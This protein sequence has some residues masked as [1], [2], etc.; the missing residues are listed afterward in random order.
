MKLIGWLVGQSVYQ[1]CISKLLW[2]V[3]SWLVAVVQVR[4]RSCLSSRMWGWWGILNAIYHS[5]ANP[6]RQCTYW[7]KAVFLFYINVWH[8]LPS[9]GSINVL[10]PKSCTAKFPV[11]VVSWY[12]AHGIL[13]VWYFFTFQR[14]CAWDIYLWFQVLTLVGQKGVLLNFFLIFLFCLLMTS[15]ILCLNKLL[16]PP[17]KS[18]PTCHTKHHD[19]VVGSV[20]TQQAAISLS[21]SFLI[22]HPSLQRDVQ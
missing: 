4:P 1:L 14:V 9:F 3:F 8:W 6:T 11:C 15:K 19:W 17:S 18:L 2:Y 12:S 7:Q 10:L 16:L 22:V 13:R 21:L 20:W 5:K